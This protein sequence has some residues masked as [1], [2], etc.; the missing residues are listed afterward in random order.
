M[1]QQVPHFFAFFL[2]NISK[3]TLS[4]LFFY[5]CYFAILFFQIPLSSLTMCLS[6]C[7]ALLLPCVCR[8]GMFTIRSILVR[9]EGDTTKEVR[10]MKE[11]GGE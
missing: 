9:H 8:R 7:S 3:D 2:F 4:S 11:S 1:P 10:K 6:A 5:L